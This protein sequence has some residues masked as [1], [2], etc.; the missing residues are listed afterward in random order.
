MIRERLRQVTA[1]CYHPL[2]EDM[3]RQGHTH[4][5]LAGGRGSAKSS[6]AALAMAAGIMADGAAGRETHGIV[7]RRY[8]NTL[9]ESAYAQMLWAIDML[10][11]SEA[12]KASVSLMTLTYLP[13]GQRI[14]F[15]GLDDPMKLKSIKASE[16]WYKYIWYEEAAELDGMES[17]RSVNQSLLRGGDSFTVMYAYNPPRSARHWINQHTAIP[18]EDTL[19]HHSTYRD[20]PPDWLGE[21]FLAEAEHLRKVRPAA[22]AHEYM[23]EVTGEGSE[24][25]DNV[26]LRPMEEEEIEHFDRIRCGIDWGYAADPFHFAQCHYDG[27]RRRLYIFGEIHGVRISN[28]KAAEMILPRAGRC[29]V[30]CD[31]AEPKSIDEMRGYGIRVRGAKKGPDSV[32]YGVKWLQDLEEIVIDP[33]RCPQTAREFTHYELER[34]REGNFKG[35]FPD[36]NNHS[37]DA[38]RYAC[39]AD[40]SAG[41]IS[42]R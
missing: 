36:K 32:E 38:V 18:R 37:I 35:G 4:Y 42:F 7:I 26:T 10:G 5:W 34:D 21:A 31:S 19:T 17:I 3:D 33:V 6:F 22:Y 15:R 9:R 29:T 20:I 24:V 16:G 14:L 30:I 13:T 12:W 27:T 41:A 1:A 8:G 11:A 25:F 28:R 2:L 23:G 39:E 40:M